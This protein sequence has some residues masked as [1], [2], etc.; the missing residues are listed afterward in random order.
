M[1]V[2]TTAIYIVRGESSISLSGLKNPMIGMFCS[3]G[4]PDVMPLLRLHHTHTHIRGKQLCMC[5]P[6]LYILSGGKAPLVC[7]D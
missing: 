6:L 5:I 4:M 1:Y 2:H 7:Q 3:T